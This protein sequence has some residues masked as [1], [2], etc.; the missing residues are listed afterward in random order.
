[1]TT[2]LMDYRTSY[3]ELK[4]I[5]EAMYRHCG[6]YKSADDMIKLILKQLKAE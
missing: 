1:M 4:A 6:D 5:R 3:A 2:K